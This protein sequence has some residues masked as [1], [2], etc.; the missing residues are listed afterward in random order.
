VEGDSNCRLADFSVP[1]T[2]G[3]YIQTF[4]VGNP[5]TTSLW[6]I[7]NEVALRID[8]IGSDLTTHMLKP[9]ADVLAQLQDL[10]PGS[11]FHQ[12]QLEP[13]EYFPRMARPSSSNPTEML[14]N[15]PDESDEFRYARAKSTGQLHALI[16]QLEQICRVVH[17]EGEN[18]K[19]FGHE[20]RNVLI[21]ASTE[22]EMYWK[23]V[24]SANGVKGESTKDYV[25][26]SHAMKLMYYKVD[27]TYYPWFEPIQPFEKWGGSISPSKDLEWYD[28]YNQVKHNRDANFPEATLRR[29]FQA[30]AGCFVMLCAQHGWGFALRGDDADRAFIRLM[31]APKWEPS[32]VYVP[33]YDTVLKPKHY[34]F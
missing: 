19:A 29:A 17:P 7:K 23:S 22:V 20:I 31:D 26:L 6:E 25:K 5:Q 16:G 15:N 2:H 18:L 13:G 3:V 10:F 27:F 11:V 34:T 1:S 24:L 9:G 8:V 28:A 12:L 30:V 33:P 4:Q 32:E 21:L 14:G